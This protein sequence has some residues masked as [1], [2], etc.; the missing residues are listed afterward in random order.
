MKNKKF[1][2]LVFLFLLFVPI[3]VNAIAGNVNFSCDKTNSKTG[4]EFDC[5]VRFNV[6]SGTLDAFQAT[7]TTSGMDVK[8][9]TKGNNSF[10]GSTTQLNKIGLY[11]MA[12]NG[13]VFVAKI[14][15]AVTTGP[16]T[17]ATITLSEMEAVDYDG[18]INPNNAMVSVRVLN[19]DTS[20]KSLTVNGAEKNGDTYVTSQS[21]VQV[22]A[23]PNGTGASVIA[24]IGSKS[25]NCG[26]NELT[27]SVRAESG[28]VEH[29]KFTVRRVCDTNSNLSSLSVN[30]GSLSPSFSQGTLNYTV[31]VDSGTTEITIDA[32]AASGK[33]NVSGTGKKNLD[34]GNNYFEIIVRAEDSSYQ[35]KYRVNVIREDNR[36]TDATLKS[37]II[38]D[39]NLSFD[40]NKTSYVVNVENSVSLVEVKATANDSKATVSGKVGKQKLQVGS[41]KIDITVLAENKKDK[42]VYTITII[43]KDENGNVGDL[44]N[45]NTL[46]TLTVSGYDI[47]FDP[48][49]EKYTLKI[50]EMVDHLDLNAI[51]ANEAAAVIILGNEKLNP[52]LNIITIEVTSEAGE[53]R[54]YKIEVILPGGDEEEP[55]AVGIENVPANN[56]NSK[57]TGSNV[58][59]IGCVI[60]AVLGASGLL[61][62]FFVI[63]K[64]NKE[65]AYSSSSTGDSKVLNSESSSLLSNEPSKESIAPAPVIEE[66]KEEIKPIQESI[67]GIQASDFNID[68]IAATVSNFNKPV[69][70]MDPNISI[71][72]IQKEL[73]GIEPKE[74]VQAVPQ[75]EITP[76]VEQV[77]V[78]RNDIP[79]IDITPI[80]QPVIKEP[81]PEVGSEPLRG[82]TPEVDSVPISPI[83]EVSSVPEVE[84][85]KPVS[86]TDLP[87]EKDDV[88]ATQMVRSIKEVSVDD[89]DGM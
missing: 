76:P 10:Q 61:L 18:Q 68:P 11:N 66:K 86:I 53:V 64:K 2:F 85:P 51:A 12:S 40:P 55:S 27:V 15:V 79:S 38:S 36:S 52:G 3:K 46:S 48:N 71:E 21:S 49:V 89:I 4:D 32:S 58:L 47:S 63:K 5:Y 59:L 37:L 9:I 74:P 25:L 28:D 80:S 50:D 83:P 17:T 1:L 33:A 22:S 57:K 19:N 75:V 88:S 30:K 41:N 45:D 84:E 65:V 35:T 20:L 70:G 72:S 87:E 6:T 82:L 23:T 78:E 24:G 14:R 62:Y 81:V 13:N 8:S 26:N 16:G 29:H 60:L 34:Y 56:G 67:P 44:N 39:A 69:E 77:Q 43:R 54:T 73:T 7:V 31:N 42:K